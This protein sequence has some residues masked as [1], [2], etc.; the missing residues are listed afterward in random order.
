MTIL[1]YGGLVILFR[2]A[3]I[4]FPILAALGCSEGSADLTTYC[5]VQPIIEQRCTT[6]HGEPRANGAPMR[7][8]TYKTAYKAR[9]LMSQ[10]VGDE[11]MP[12]VGNP[13]VDDNEMTKDE[14]EL[15]LT[16]LD[17][18]AEEGPEDCE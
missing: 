5:D 2:H 15:L 13:A 8:N 9:G 10:W 14:R 18:G 16:W 12:P 4:S 7:L 17:D 3:L 6:C 1:N 11:R